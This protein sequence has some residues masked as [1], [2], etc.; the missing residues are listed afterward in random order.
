MLTIQADIDHNKNNQYLIIQNQLVDL[1]WLY[2]NYCWVAW[3]I[4]EIIPNDI[5]TLYAYKWLIFEI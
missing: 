5:L 2:F 3:L 4:I 1:L